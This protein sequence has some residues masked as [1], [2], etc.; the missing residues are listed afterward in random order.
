MHFQPPERSKSLPI[1][2]LSLEET[3]QLVHLVG[4]CYGDKYPDK[5]FYDAEGLRR[6][7][8]EGR[9]RS[10]VIKDAGEVVGHLCLVP[11]H[12]EN[13]WLFFC[14]LSHPDYRGNHF[15]TRLMVFMCEY[16]YKI[17]KMGCYSE[18]VMYNL[19][20]QRS[21]I[22][23]GGGECAFF[24]AR[25]PPGYKEG[26]KNTMLFFFPAKGP[27]PPMECCCSYYVTEVFSIAHR[28]N[29]EVVSGR[30]ARLGRENIFEIKRSPA[31]KTAELLV[32][33]LTPHEDHSS[34]WEEHLATLEQ[35]PVRG[36]YLN[37]SHPQVDKW[38]EMLSKRG[39]FFAGI[40]PYLFSSGSALILQNIAP[41]IPLQSG[42]DL[43]VSDFGRRIFR[44]CERS[45]RSESL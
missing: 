17:G 24:Y 44:F 40:L 34:F 6:V 3:D 13:V 19:A 22:L 28:F 29:I 1:E 9:L 42:D 15:L 11:S 37:L 14:G 36:I 30:G 2:W 16:V 12:L 31:W 25:I 5:T 32:E 21:S 39:Y 7:F 20:S 26:W 18:M 23:A 45:R 41:R 35:E 27:L 8:R 4:L 33:D 38:V 43:F 10:A